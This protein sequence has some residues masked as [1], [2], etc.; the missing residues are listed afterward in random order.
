MFK[1]PEPG[2]SER[3]DILN[4][5]NTITAV[6]SS[7]KVYELQPGACSRLKG[8]NH[9]NPTLNNKISWRGVQGPGNKF[10]VHNATSYRSLA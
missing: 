1:L 5:G 8:H 7:G 10:F 2:E 9:H 3:Q 6:D 4:Q